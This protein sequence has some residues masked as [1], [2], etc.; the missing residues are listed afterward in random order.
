MKLE[1]D[2]RSEIATDSK[3]FKNY[4][5]YVMNSRTEKQT[6]LTAVQCFWEYFRHL[7]DLKRLI[8]IFV[9]ES[10]CIFAPDS[11][12]KIFNFIL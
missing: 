9:L 10:R 4:L 2:L 1:K 8:T 5:R 12:E 7:E 3:D 6:I 11:T